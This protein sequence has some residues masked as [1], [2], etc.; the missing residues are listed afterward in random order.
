MEFIREEKRLKI[1]IDDIDRKFLKEVSEDNH[2]QLCTEKAE[3]DFFAPYFEN[4]EFEWVFPEDINALTSA[5]IIGV[6]GEGE[7]LNII[8][9]YGYMDYAI[10]SMLEELETHGEIFLQKG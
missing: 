4:G 8:E 6:R 3:Y 1:T 2:N 10:Y 5:P 7:N 9:A